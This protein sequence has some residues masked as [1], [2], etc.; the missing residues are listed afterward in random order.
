MPFDFSSD[1]DVGRRPELKSDEKSKDIPIVLEIPRCAIFAFFMHRY[2]LSE[3]HS[4]L[5]LVGVGLG[6]CNTPAGLAV[7]YCA[8]A[9]G[10]A[11][12]K[13]LASRRH[14]MYISC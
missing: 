4:M 6:D 1:L 10:F 14:A 2:T 7:E 5:P 11:A 3:H 9:S 12:S 13:A 8:V